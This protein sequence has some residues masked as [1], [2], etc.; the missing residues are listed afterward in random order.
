MFKMCAHFLQA[1]L[2]HF[3]TFALFEYL[4]CY[5][6]QNKKEK[7]ENSSRQLVHRKLFNIKPTDVTVTMKVLLIKDTHTHIKYPFTNTDGNV[8]ER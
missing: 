7:R 1:F 3:D 2:P 6:I 4:Y 5:A 8:R